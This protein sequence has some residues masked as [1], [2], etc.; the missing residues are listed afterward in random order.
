MKILCI[1][2]SSKLCSVAILEDQTLLKKI[3]LDN[4]L[5]HS[6]ILLVLIQQIL[7]DL[8]L[9]LTDIN[10]I[11]VDIGPGSFTGLRI[12]IATAKAFCDSL[13]IPCIGIN[14]L[15]ILAHNIK[16]NAYICSTI[17]CKN[18][19]CYFALYK[20][21]NENYQVL[22]KPTSETIKNVINLLDTK[23]KNQ[24]IIFVGDGIPSKS[25]STYLSS[26]NLGLAGFNKFISNGKI[27]ENITPLYLKKS[28]AE[29]LLEQK[30]KQN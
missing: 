5:T 12:G 6:E 11:S 15:E 7:Q 3:E 21:S 28:Q 23:Y 16:E 22:E 18:N 19:N 30:T 2:T 27:G 24:E 20:Y 14:S 26:Y 10:L 1:D 4:G 8:N 17:D 29:R 25:V 9:S 13:N